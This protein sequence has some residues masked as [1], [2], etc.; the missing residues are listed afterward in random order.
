MLASAQLD[1]LD[2]HCGPEQIALRVSVADSY[3]QVRRLEA[4]GQGAPCA[5]GRAGTGARPA[6]VRAPGDRGGR[7]NR[8]RGRVA[9][10]RARSAAA[11]EALR[12]AASAGLE[13]LT[14]EGDG[15]ACQ[16]LAAAARTLQPAGEIDPRLG[17]LAE[18]FESLRYEAEELARELRD[19]VAEIDGDEAGAWRLRP[20]SRRSRS[21]WRCSRGSSASMAAR[22][23]RSFGT[24]T[25][26]G[27]GST[28]SSAPRSRSRPR[29][30]SLPAPGTELEPAW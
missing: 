23:R 2:A 10:G 5:R 6:R 25:A 30:W 14:P 1:V 29:N 18:R 22:S 12:Y 11:F 4:P 8:G 13:A 17:G 28:S 20:A 7:A 21:G 26:A 27:R 9:G 16:L 24:G 3:D 15:G 19:Y